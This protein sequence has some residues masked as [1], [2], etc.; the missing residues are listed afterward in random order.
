MGKFADSLTAWAAETDA[1]MTAVYRM[2]VDLLG[3]EM[4]TT[5]A[6]GG[7]VPFKDGNL[8]RSVLASTQGMPK[9]S[10]GPFSGGNVGAVAATL[11]LGQPV[12]LGY[13]AAYA[14]RVNYGFVGADKL[15]RVYNQSG[16]HFLEY[17]IEMWPTIVKLASEQAELSVKA[18][19]K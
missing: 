8:Y 16:A 15:G 17:A 14:R 4:S 5:A 6:G 11:E 10:E 7:K 9:I 13:Q 2:S 18:R 19:K 1:R 12:W 3:E